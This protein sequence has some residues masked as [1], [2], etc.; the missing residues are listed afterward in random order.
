MTNVHGTLMK[1]ELLYIIPA[2]FTDDENDQIIK[3]V[4]S[5][6][7]KVGV[8]IARNDNLG[9]LKLAYPIKHVR[10][11]FYVLVEFEGETKAVQQI[12]R[13]LRL[14]PEVLRHQAIK[15]PEKEL[16]EEGKAKKEIKMISYE[17]P[18]RD[19]EKEPAKREK[20]KPAPKKI[21]LEELDKKLDEI[22]EKDV[23][24]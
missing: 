10:H 18:G 1:Y 19:E 8:K 13:E 15:L 20:P 6:L 2:Q 4:T 9:K 21:N 5:V 22:L 7:E 24:V 14:M 3:K 16:A 17:A 11:G 23:E 12:E